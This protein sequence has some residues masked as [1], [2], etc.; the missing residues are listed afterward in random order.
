M[1]SLNKLL[2]VVIKINH[3][4]VIV[5]ETLAHC[6]WE[7]NAYFRNAFKNYFQILS[8]AFLPRRPIFSEWIRRIRTRIRTGTSIRANRDIAFAIRSHTE[9]W[10]PAT[11]KMWVSEIWIFSDLFCL[12]CLI[13]MWLV[14]IK[15]DLS[16]FLSLSSVFSLLAFSSAFLCQRFKVK[17]W[18]C[19][20]N[21]KT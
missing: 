20:Y 18:T 5:K 12:I 6:T 1:N 2:K 14:K 17:K 13:F 19:H 16:L 8:A 11:I 4:T 21:F 9:K 7:I 15:L 3:C 10:W